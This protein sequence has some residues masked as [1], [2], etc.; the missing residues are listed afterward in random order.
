MKISIISRQ[1]FQE[2]FCSTE[3]WG[4][5]FR[6]QESDICQKQ[7]SSF[8]FLAPPNRLRLCDKNGHM[9]PFAGVESFEICMETVRR[10]LKSKS[11]TNISWKLSSEAIWRK[12]RRKF[13]RKKT[14]PNFETWKV[15]QSL[16]K[17]LRS[18]IRNDENWK[19]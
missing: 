3:F 5:K 15:R 18:S 4:Y 17:F 13:K 12:V 11:L 19:L 16:K 2:W 1:S 6:S 9:S 7:K 10:I 8:T 14:F